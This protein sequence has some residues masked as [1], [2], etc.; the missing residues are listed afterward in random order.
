M[1]IM[2]FIT[3]WNIQTLLP[4]FPPFTP[5]LGDQFLSIRTYDSNQPVVR[6]LYAMSKRIT[7]LDLI[8]ESGFYAYVSH[9]GDTRLWYNPNV[10]TDEALNSLVS[11]LNVDNVFDPRAMQSMGFTAAFFQ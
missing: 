11:F 5:E 10:D 7:P 3:E 8:Y 6:C 4:L 9:N 1:S 2:C